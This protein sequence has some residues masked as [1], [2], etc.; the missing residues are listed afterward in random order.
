MY[1][2]FGYNA[3][4]VLPCAADASC[5][6]PA[7][8]RS[9]VTVTL[10]KSWHTRHH[11]DEQHLIAVSS[12]ALGRHEHLLGLAS[13]LRVDGTLAV[14]IADLSHAPLRDILHSTAV[15]A[16]LMTLGATEIEMMLSLVILARREPRLAARAV[17]TL[18]LSVSQHMVESL[19][20]AAMQPRWRHRHLRD[21]ARSSGAHYNSRVALQRATQDVAAPLVASLGVGQAQAGRLF[22]ALWG[23]PF[24]LTQL[25]FFVESQRAPLYAA[26]AAVGSLN[27]RAAE[28]IKMAVDTLAAHMDLDPSRLTALVVGCKLI[29]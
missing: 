3:S 10:N 26:V 16:M 1:V 18:G 19:M 20:V 5:V 29:R 11:M 8:L 9:V 13:A 27:C 7:S 12:L 14:A 15:R 28:E 6:V 25:P 4:I 17:D 24:V 21:A 22:H 2:C 23:H